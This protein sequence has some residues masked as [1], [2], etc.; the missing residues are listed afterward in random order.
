MMA[1][2]YLEQALIMSTWTRF[3]RE[4]ERIEKDAGSYEILYKENFA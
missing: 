2:Q 1:Q 3:S 4:E